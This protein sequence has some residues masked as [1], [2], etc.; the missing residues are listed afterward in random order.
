M[1]FLHSTNLNLPNYFLGRKSRWYSFPCSVPSR[2]GEFMFPKRVSHT[3]L[4]IF[5][6]GADTFC[7]FWCWHFWLYAYEDFNKPR[8]YC[9]L[10]STI[11][12]SITYHAQQTTS[13]YL[14]SHETS[15]NFQILPLL[16]CHA[17]L[18]LVIQSC[19]ALCNLMECSPPGS[20]VHGDSP[21]K[22]TRVGCHALLKGIFPTQGSNLVSHIAD[23]FFNIWA[24]RK[25]LH[26]TLVHLFHRYFRYKDQLAKLYRIMK[27]LTLG[28][29]GDY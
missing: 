1:E 15:T 10:A 8:L 7:M 22:N 20:S 11:Q 9:Y 19:S 23:E 17:V 29:V 27:F 28:K 21:G 18:F 4:Q 5:F 13:N 26:A 16:Q 14:A 2:H 12:L 24:T 3:C 25:V 6:P